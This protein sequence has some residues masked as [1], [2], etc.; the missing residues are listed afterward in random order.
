M[1]QQP[2]QKQQHQPQQQPQQQQQHQQPHQQQQ[3]DDITDGNITERPISTC[4]SDSWD[5][6]PTIFVGEDGFIDCTSSIAPSSSISNY[7]TQDS[8]FSGSR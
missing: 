1:R 3:Q 5:N 7:D 6:L 8:Y 4:L 2:Q